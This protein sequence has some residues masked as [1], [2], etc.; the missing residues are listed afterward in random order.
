YRLRV[1]WQI[2][3]VIAAV[4]ILVP[5]MPN[6]F[7]DRIDQVLTGEDVTGSGRT[8]IW[9][10]G[11]LA[12]SRFGVLGAGLANFPLVFHSL[13]YQWRGPHNEYLGAWVE[14]GFVGLLLFVA[15][16]VGHARGAR[17]ITTETGSFTTA[18]RTASEAACLALVL[19][20]FLS[21]VL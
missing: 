5:F 16:I 19:V 15:T 6:L 1:R 13:A 3:L 7:F 21:D 4:A 8:D 11:L 18:F 10:T 17:P 20:A 9:Q 12:L 2:I 14:L